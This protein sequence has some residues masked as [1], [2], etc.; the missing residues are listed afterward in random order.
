ME[1]E[2]IIALVLFG[3]LHWVLAIMLLN[4]L[5]EREKVLGGRKWIWG[6]AIVAITFIG[7]LLYL[8]CH[9]KIFYDS[10]LK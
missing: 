6:I 7:S 5:A 8:L 9:P 3:I 10:D 4:D 1:P 2:R